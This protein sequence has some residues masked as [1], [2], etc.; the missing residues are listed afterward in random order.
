MLF[1]AKPAGDRGGFRHGELRGAC[2][3]AGLRVCKGPTVLSRHCGSP[4]PPLVECVA[5]VQMGY[6]H[7]PA[8]ITD[9]R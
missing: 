2:C 3:N 5:E 6:S 4:P 9:V 1:E 7:M 8:H